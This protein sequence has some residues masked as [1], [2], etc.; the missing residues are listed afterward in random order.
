MAMYELRHQL[1]FQQYHQL[2]LMYSLNSL[3]SGLDLNAPMP[4]NRLKMSMPGGLM[5][6]PTKKANPCGL[7]FLITTQNELISVR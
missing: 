1:G 6:Q 4:L 3:A 7:A 5:A 2:K